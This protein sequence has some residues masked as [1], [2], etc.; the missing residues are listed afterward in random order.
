MDVVQAGKLARQR[1]WALVGNYGNGNLGDEATASVVIEALRSR[2]PDVRLVMFTDNPSDARERH[3]IEALPY[4]SCGRNTTSE[5]APASPPSGPHGRRPDLSHD[6]SHTKATLLRTPLRVVKKVL[7][8]GVD[9]AREIATW[10]ACFRQARTLDAVIFS[11]GGQLEDIFGGATNYPL[12]LCKWALLGRLVGAKVV[13][14]SV[15][16]SRTGSPLSRILLRAA[17][18]LSHYCSFR[19]A[20]SRD[21]VAEH[22]GIT[23]KTAV[24]PDLVFGLSRTVAQGHSRYTPGVVAINAFPHYA[25]AYWPVEDSARYASYVGRFAE[26]AMRLLGDGYR[27]IL[28]PTQ[29]RADRVPLDHLERT[30]LERLSPRIS[31]RV[32]RADVV[33]VKDV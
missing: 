26:L 14:L 5:P 25:K 28:F 11:G 24:T 12:Q 8:T 31:E 3:G 20:A 30:L 32:Q 15:G 21:L 17:L 13:F 7:R 19:D 10:P 18:R 9:L 23:G 4:R 33:T 16:A 6:K 27:L 1:V 29:I 2:C 22:I